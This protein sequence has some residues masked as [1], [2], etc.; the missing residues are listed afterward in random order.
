MYCTGTIDHLLDRWPWKSHR[1]HFR[2]IHQTHKA[3][4]RSWILPSQKQS[5]KIQDAS[6]N[7]AGETWC[8]VEFRKPRKG[9]FSGTKVMKT[10]LS[11]ICLA[12]RPWTWIAF[13]LVFWIPE[14]RWLSKLVFHHMTLT[15][16]D[17]NDKPWHVETHGADIGTKDDATT[18]K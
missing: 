9:C 11:P 7:W 6:I 1:G 14:I 12:R 17:S 5:L 13:H 15:Q 18:P 10:P 3:S 16:A 2:D 8:V 4:W